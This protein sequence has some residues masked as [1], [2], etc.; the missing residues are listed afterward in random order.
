MP[1]TQLIGHVKGIFPVNIQQEVE[2]TYCNVVL[3][4]FSYY[5]PGIAVNKPVQSY[6][7]IK[8][9]AIYLYEY[10][11][12]HVYVYIFALFIVVTKILIAIFLRI[13][14]TFFV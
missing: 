12:V 11:C 5:A 8:T 13:R 2:F 7:K 1:T 4:H 3:L 14:F 9:E 10:L 6:M